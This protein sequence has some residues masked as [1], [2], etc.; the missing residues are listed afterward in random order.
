M[1]RVLVT[2]ASGF[3]GSYIVSQGLELGYEVWAAV[4]GTSSRAYLQDSRIRFIELSLGSEERLVQELQA[5]GVRFDYV[6]HAAGA[7]K[8]LDIDDFYRTN[9]QGTCNLV[10]ALIKAD[11]VP[12]RFVFVSSLSVFGAVR[13]TPVR[14]RP[15]GYGKGDVIAPEE[16]IYDPILL[17]DVPQPNTAYGKSKLAAED[18]LR[19][20]DVSRFPCDPA[21]DG[22]VRPS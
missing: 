5:S 18:F 6:V 4:R 8:C 13:E 15:E 10:N 22:C 21:P 9:T 16:S 2:G 17:T 7:T 12:D 14:P 19:T 1:A 11:M 20:L 3:I